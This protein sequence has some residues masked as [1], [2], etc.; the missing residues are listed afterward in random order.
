MGLRT[1]LAIFY[2]PDHRKTASVGDWFLQ[3]GKAWAAGE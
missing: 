3:L 2:I 1:Q